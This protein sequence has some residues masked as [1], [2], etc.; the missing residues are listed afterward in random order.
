[1]IDKIKEYITEVEQFTSSDKEEIEAFRIRYL[2]KKGVLNDFFAAFKSVPNGEKKEF[3]QAV[4]HLKNAA[5][6][7]V[8]ALK[9][10]LESQADQKSIYGDLTR[11]AEPIPLGARH[12]ISIV[13]N[14]IIDIFSRIGF[15]VS[16]GP[17]IEDDW[18][19]FTALNLPEYH[20]ARDMQ[21]TFFIQT[22]PDILLRTHTS[23][24]Q[25][26]YMEEHK[27]PIRTISPGRVYRNEAISARSHCFFHQVEGLYIDK[28]VSFADLK[29]TLQYFTKEMFGKSKIRLRPSY[30]PFTE[31]SAEVDVYWGLETESD[32]KITKGTGWLEIMGCGMVDPNVLKNCNIDS[33]EYSGFAFGIGIDRIAM[34]LHQIPDIRMLS[35]N[36]VR[37]LGQFKSVL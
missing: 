35:E 37:F 20:P 15:N 7:K 29:Q 17:E 3:G 16:E 28:G 19:N 2:G 1:M 14:Q 10:A 23:S 31:P 26:R 18:H 36:D 32:Y 21:D 5:Q 13:K 11:P 9:E 8:N 24:V 22:D 30:F 34:L 12:P 4:N 25:V 6:E 27:P 33:T